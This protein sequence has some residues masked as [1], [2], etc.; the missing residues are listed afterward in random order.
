MG[1]RGSEARAGAATAGTATG[2]TE[3]VII[4]GP[5]LAEAAAWPSAPEVTP[6]AD[7][8]TAVILYTSGT[9]G[10]PKGAELTH[11]NL[12]RNAS[13]TATSLLSLSPEDVV[14][15]CLP[16]FHSFGQTCGLNAAVLSG[17]CLTLI[18]RFS[19]AAAIQV[20]GCDRVTVFEGCRPCTS[21]CCTRLSLQGLSRPGTRLPGMTS[22]RPRCGCARPAAR[23]SRWSA[24]RFEKRFGTV[25]LEGY[26]LSETSPVATFNRADRRGPGSIGVPVEGVE[27]RLVEPT[28]RSRRLA[29]SARSPFA[30]TT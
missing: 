13:V 2:G 1:K 10:T 5:T 29:R 11:A 21:R 18:S 22:T 3:A 4:G 9:T 28:A 15:G 12:H 23:R 14:M 30:G 20:I 17:A 6:R 26:G 8:D 27:L 25:I 7:D 16:L 24:A 19:A